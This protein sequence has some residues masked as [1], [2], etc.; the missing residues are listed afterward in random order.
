MLE[1]VEGELRLLEVLE[2]LDVLEVMRC[3]L[4]LYILP[5]EIAAELG[6][7]LPQFVAVFSPRL[8]PCLFAALTEV[9]EQRS[10]YW[11][12]GQIVY[13]ERE[14]RSMTPI[15]KILLALMSVYTMGP[16]I[17]KLEASILGSFYGP[18]SHPAPFL[19]STHDFRSAVF[20]RLSKSRRAAGV[21]TWRY[22]SLESH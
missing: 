8:D 4:H 2:L 22:R 16:Q 20:F 1:A 10:D 3:M 18:A 5:G 6:W 15:Q 7:F 19:S 21:Q 9:R 12:T 11:L 13:L 14:V 17:S